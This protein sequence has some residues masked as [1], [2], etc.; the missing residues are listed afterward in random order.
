MLFFFL[1]EINL[2]VFDMLGNIFA[3]EVYRLTKAHDAY[4]HDYSDDDDEEEDGLRQSLPRNSKFSQNDVIMLTLQQAGA[5][6]FFGSTSI[7]TNKDAIS[8]E[9]RVLNTGPTYVDVAI[10]GGAFEA[11]FGP[12][13]NNRGPSGKG[14]KNMRLRIDR[15][16]SNVPY[17]RMVDAIGQLT[18]VQSNGNEDLSPRER[19]CVDRSIR[20]SILSTFAYSNAGS[21]MYGDGD[22]CKLNDLVSIKM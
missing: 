22:A 6:D 7:P 20:Q 14:D 10:N 13:P 21:P 5:G 2:I 8:L 9:A 16:F 12:A 1:N 11:T 15:Y 3:D 17:N 4:T 18:S 19:T